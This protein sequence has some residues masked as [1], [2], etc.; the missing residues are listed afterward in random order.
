MKILAYRH[1][2]NFTFEAILYAL[3]KTK[4][5][6][7]YTS[8]EITANEIDS[9][10][11]DII[12]HN[13]PEAEKFPIKNKAISININDTESEYSFSFSNSKSK[14]YIEPFITIRRHEVTKEEEEKFFSNVLYIGQI[15]VFEKLVP[16]LTDKENDII[17]KFFSNVPHNISGYCGVCNPEDYYKFY[18]MSNA[19]LV[20]KDDKNRIMDIIASDG[21]P[22]IYDGKN[23][24][25][26]IEKIND[27]IH[28]K[29]KYEIEGYSKEYILNN[30][31]AF[32]R[33]SKIFK[34]VGLNKI[35]EDILKQ[36]NGNW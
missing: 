4:Y 35:S 28:N 10:S 7:G 2:T 1:N 14:N 31:T 17:F 24:D 22:I 36:K 5:T 18:K 27:A 6:I 11:P 12:I 25:E 9:F 21:N 34:K 13:I 3:S 20:M 15:S 23:K 29:A 30:H 33:V 19:S 8:G 32:D 16:F 26:C